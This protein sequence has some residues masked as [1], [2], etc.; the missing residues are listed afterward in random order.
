MEGILLYIRRMDN[1][2]SLLTFVMNIC[3][4][5]MTRCSFEDPLI[6]WNPAFGLLISKLSCFSG[7][8]P[9]GVGT[10]TLKYLCSK[11]TPGLGFKPASRIR[12]SGDFNWSKGD[13]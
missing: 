2:D 7:S 8:A 1:V 3:L 6:Y 5:I 10:K 4:L 12:L 11:I 9:E 13:C